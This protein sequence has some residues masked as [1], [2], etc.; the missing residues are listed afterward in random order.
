[1]QP[2][3]RRPPTDFRL[4]SRPKLETARLAGFRLASQD[5][6]DFLAY[7][8]PASADLDARQKAATC[9]VF[10]GR[11]RNVEQQGNVAPPEN[12]ISGQSAWPGNHGVEMRSVRP[13]LVR[14]S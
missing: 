6:F 3:S 13:S 2:V 4:A 9:P 12:V 8:E 14:P 7:V 1:M 11:D 5:S 10:N